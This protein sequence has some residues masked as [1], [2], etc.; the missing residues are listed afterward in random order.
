MHHADQRIG[1]EAAFEQI[2]LGT[3]LDQV[4]LLQQV[5]IVAQDDDRQLGRR[6]HQQQKCF[7]TPCRRQVPIHHHRIDVPVLPYA[8]SGL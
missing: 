8:L 2:V 3:V 4:H 7:E 1:I 5:R 6:A